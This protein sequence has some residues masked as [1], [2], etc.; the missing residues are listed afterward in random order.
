ML[1]GMDVYGKSLSNPQWRE[2]ID[3]AET[4]QV[5]D[6]IWNVNPDDPREYDAIF[7]G[8]GA[9]GRFGSAFLRARGG[10]QPGGL[11]IDKMAEMNELFLN[12]EHFVQLCRLRAG[13]SE[14]TN[15]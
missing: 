9:G 7:V 13:Q 5:T 6:P 3:R 1:V 4:G 11:T 15:L 12:P 2:V 14:L 10:R 8:G